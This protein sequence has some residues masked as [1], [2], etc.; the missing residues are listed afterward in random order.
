MI[1]LL[2]SPEAWAALLTL[3]AS[4]LLGTAAEAK[5]PP[6]K[7][8]SHSARGM[9]WISAYR[10][11]YEWPQGTLQIV[12]ARAGTTRAVLLPAG[13][14]STDV[15]GPLVLLGCDEPRVYQLWNSFTREA[16]AIDLS[17]C[18]SHQR[19]IG[20]GRIGRYWIAGSYDTGYFDEEM[21]GT[22]HE[23]FYA[24]YVNRATGECRIYDEAGLN[25]DV[26]QPDLP[27]PYYGVPDT[28]TRGKNF[29]VDLRPSGGSYVKLCKEG[30][31]WRLLS[32][33][34]VD[35]SPGPNLVAWLTKNRL[36]AYLPASRRRLSWRVPGAS[37]A[38]QPYATVIG[39][40]AYAY[41]YGDEP[42]HVAIY[43]ADLS[44][45]VGR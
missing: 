41:T 2:T 6:L 17:R 38:R 23:V 3:T 14:E 8:V 16:T 25:K 34:G 13:C 35:V 24:V 19:E 26:D 45:L 29:I 44:R 20:M 28:C 15:N 42:G 9:T 43:A 10:G 37:Y 1:D 21:D 30:A 5:Q 4:F 39:D 12:N 18:G 36:Y 27:G 11:Y 33:Y 32:R 7:F 22:G 40:R 31:R